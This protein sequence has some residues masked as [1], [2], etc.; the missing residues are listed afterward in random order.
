M[1]ELK[2]KVLKKID[3]NVSAMHYGTAI[4]SVGLFIAIVGALIAAFG[5]MSLFATK[6][7]IA[8]LITCGIVIGFLNITSK[9]TVTFLVA[10]I[11]IV[12]LIGPF[13]ANIIQTFGIGQTGSKLIGELFKNLIG[14]VV[15]AAIIV[16]VKALVVTAKSEE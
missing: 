6:L 2:K 9:E 14:L 7:L 15:P 10:S 4:F 12:M 3:K 11:V 16:A 5:T 1:K 13:M 8:A